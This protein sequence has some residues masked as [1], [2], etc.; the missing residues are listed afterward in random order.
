MELLTAG[1]AITV[2]YLFASLR[3][4]R[5]SSQSTSSALASTDSALSV[6]TRRNP[7]GVYTT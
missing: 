2:A 7:I 6:K 1:L 3:V 4:M 5:E